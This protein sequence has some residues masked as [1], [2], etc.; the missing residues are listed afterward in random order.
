MSTMTPVGPVD[1]VFH[2]EASNFNHVGTDYRQD[3]PF[4][5]RDLFVYKGGADQYIGKS[6]LDYVV[7]PRTSGYWEI[8]MGELQPSTLG[9]AFPGYPLPGAD[10]T[11]TSR[12]NAEDSALI[13]GVER[14]GFK[15]EILAFDLGEHQAAR[16]A[17]RMV[18]ASLGKQFMGNKEAVGIVLEACEQS[19]FTPS[20][21]NQRLLD[22]GII[23]SLAGGDTVVPVLEFA[24][25]NV[26]GRDMEARES[27]DL[28]LAALTSNLTPLDIL[29]L[30]YTLADSQIDLVGLQKTGLAYSVPASNT[31]QWDLMLNG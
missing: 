18:T 11:V 16:E 20:S 25:K 2:D 4:G 30:A 15:N 12:L 23:K 28:S 26:M 6:G 29:N 14:I 5:G 8:T 7:F 27:L 1:Q 22:A 3:R 24:F 10:V 19:G 31:M 17:A 13:T 9:N 21:I